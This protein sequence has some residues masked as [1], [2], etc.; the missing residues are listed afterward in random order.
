MALFQSVLLASALLLWTALSMSLVASFTASPQ[1]HHR[2]RTT[3]LALVP[4]PLPAMATTAAAS[5]LTVT[6]SAVSLLQ[7][8]SAHLQ[9]LSRTASPLQDGVTSYMNTEE[10]LSACLSSSSLQLSVLKD[11]VIPTAEEIAAK[12]FNFNVIFWGGGFIAPLIAT[13]FYF[14]FRFWEK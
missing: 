13:V 3:K 10:S 6:L 11:R 1:S 5:P 4:V 2:K 14:G 8:P 9:Q 7:V 12:K